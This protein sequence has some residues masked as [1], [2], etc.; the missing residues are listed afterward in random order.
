MIEKNTKKIEYFYPTF[1]SDPMYRF[2]IVLTVASV[3]GLQGWRTLFNN[4]AVEVVGLD[5]W[6]IGIIQS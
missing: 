2:L 1:A 5:G 3:L 6:H 4:F